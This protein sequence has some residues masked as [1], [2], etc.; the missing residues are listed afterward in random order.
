MSVESFSAQVTVSVGLAKVAGTTTPPEV[1]WPMKVMPPTASTTMV[2]P[3]TEVRPSALRPPAAVTTTPQ[4]S[5]SALGAKVVF[6][7]T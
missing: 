6:K 5:S 7:A 2:E 4:P 1:A 3:P